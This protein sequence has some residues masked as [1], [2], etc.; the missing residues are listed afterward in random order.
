MPGHSIRPAAFGPADGLGD[1]VPGRP[2]LS[3]YKFLLFQDLRPLPFSINLRFS[4]VL[5]LL[6]R[7]LTVFAKPR[8]PCADVGRHSSTGRQCET[9]CRRA[10]ASRAKS[11]KYLLCGIAKL[12]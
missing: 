11:A 2:A 4:R 7:L 6:C 1:P 12:T 8:A 5:S 3:P 10:T 9:P